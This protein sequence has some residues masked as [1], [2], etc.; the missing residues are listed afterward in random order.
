MSTPTDQL[1]PPVMA[2]GDYTRYKIILGSL[3]LVV[4][5][6]VAALYIS[7][8]LSASRGLRCSFC[9]A[10]LRASIRSRRFAYWL[11]ITSSAKKMC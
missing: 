9:P 7:P 3:G 10:S 2:P 6:L 4:P 8:V 5:L 11:G 1:T